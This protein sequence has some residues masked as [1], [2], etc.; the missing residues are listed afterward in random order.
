MS[1]IASPP[2]AVW[3]YETSDSGRWLALFSIATF[4]RF[5]ASKVYAHPSR[6]TVAKRSGQKLDTLKRQIGKLRA[7]GSLVRHGRGWMLEVEAVDWPDYLRP[8]AAPP[9]EILSAEISAGRKRALI[10]LWSFADYDCDGPATVRPTIA[11]VATRTG[12]SARSVRDQ[13]A[14]LC[15]HGYAS[16]NEDALVLALTQPPASPLEANT[17][18]P[19][20][21]HPAATVHPYLA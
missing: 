15:K 17:Q 3:Q 1:G 12:Q 18:P 5:G 9:E 4:G 8:P 10:G 14:W 11:E 20:Y 21:P 19:Q 7:A 2:R 16:R 13:I 6:E